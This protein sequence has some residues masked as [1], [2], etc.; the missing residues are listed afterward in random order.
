MKKK[1]LKMDQ[2]PQLPKKSDREP[3][4]F[5]IYKEQIRFWNGRR[6]LCQ[7]K[8]HICNICNPE[9]AE[10]KQQWFQKNPEKQRQYNRQWRQNNPE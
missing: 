10:K 4:T 7:H 5:Y 9:A 1:K 8:K 2:L 3:N 6:L